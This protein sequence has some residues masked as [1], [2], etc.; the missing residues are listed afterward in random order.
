MQHRDQVVVITGASSGIGRATARAFA[1]RGSALVLAARAE[2]RLGEVEAECARLG[3]RVLAVEADVSRHEDVERLAQRAVDGF[4]SFDVW[5]NNAG[6][7]AFGRID[8]VPAAD[9]EQV[10]RTN[11]CGCLFGARV[12]VRRFREHGRGT[13]INVSSI[14]SRLGQAYSAAYT[15]SKWGVTG[16][17]QALRAE[18]AGEP[19]IHVCTVMPAFIDTPLFEHAANYTGHPLQPVSPIYSPDLVAAAIVGLIDRPQAEIVVGD[20]GRLL[21]GSHA[22]LPET[23]NR[24]M[25]GQIDHGVLGNGYRAP[26]SG[27]LHAPRGGTA[28]SGGWQETAPFRGETFDTTL[29]GLAIGTLTLA[30]LVTATGYLRR[31]RDA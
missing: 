19:D 22:L 18:L 23:T 30:A 15:A 5:V 2:E 13:L 11:L 26:A 31:R 29:R 12:A 17:G 14:V 4:G 28:T 1:E 16:L 8:E 21:T 27:N 7:I 10:I 24:L 25:R 9:H 20:G 3:A 6:V